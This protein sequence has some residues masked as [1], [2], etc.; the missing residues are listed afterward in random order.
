[1]EIGAP[2]DMHCARNMSGIVKKHIFVRLNDP[3]PFVFQ[4]FLEPIR[5]YQRFRMRVLRRMRSHSSKNFTLLSQDGKG[6]YNLIADGSRQ[7]DPPMI[8][9]QFLCP[10]SSSLAAA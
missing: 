6:F 5:F 4:V 3:D 10:S 9:R 1:L 2:I 7:G 8:G